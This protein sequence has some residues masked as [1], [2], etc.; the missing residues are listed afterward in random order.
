ML[1]EKGQRLLVF[2]ESHQQ[3]TEKLNTRRAVVCSG[4]H[5][6]VKIIPTCVDNSYVPSVSLY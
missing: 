1:E 5:Q 3:T 2:K 4:L 6:V